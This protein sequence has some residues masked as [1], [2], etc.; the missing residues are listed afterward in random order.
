MGKQK[1]DQGF[2][3]KKK[4]KEDNNTNTFELAK[5][6]VAKGL[7]SKAILGYEKWR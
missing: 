5:Q 7:V 1:H 3:K 6:L 2:K 4:T